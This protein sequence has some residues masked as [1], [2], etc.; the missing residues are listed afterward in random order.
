MNFKLIVKMKNRMG[1]IIG[2]SFKN[3]LKNKKNCLKVR[4]F[5]IDL[6]YSKIN[7]KTDQI[8]IFILYFSVR[9]CKMLFK[10]LI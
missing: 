3:M 1:A 4:S 5:I 8:N 6:L 9:T 7:N 2:Q 10:S